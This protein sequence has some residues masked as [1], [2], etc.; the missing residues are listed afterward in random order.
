[1]NIVLY[2]TDRIKFKWSKEYTDELL[3][4]LEK[5]GHFTK[6]ISDDTDREIV[7]HELSV[8]DYFIGVKSPFD[9]IQ[10]DAKRIYIRGASKEGEGPI[11]PIP[12]AG[13][14]E[15]LPDRVDCLF[16]DELCMK[17]ITA[18]DILEHMC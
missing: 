6:V 5:R 7:E 13:C 1:M 12:C 14:V 4:K 11:S 3:S 16:A 8:C 2:L 18:N 10:T 17:E 9:D 15:N